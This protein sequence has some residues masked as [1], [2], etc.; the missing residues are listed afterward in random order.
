MFKHI[1]NYQFKTLVRSKEMWFWSL[2]F[3]LVLAT[4]FN[5]AFSNMSSG[6]SFSSVNIAVVNNE[7]F[8]QE[9]HFKEL[10]EQL[11]QDNDDKI[12][13]VK[14]IDEKEAQ[15]LLK[16]NEISGYIIVQDNINLVFKNVGFNQTIVKSVVDSYY[17]TMSVMKNV[18]KHNPEAIKDGVLELLGEKHNFLKDTSN[19]DVDVMVSYFYALIAMVC[20]YGAN[21]S[22]FM[23][24]QSEANL[25]K[26]GARTSVA[27]TH[28]FK[29]IAASLLIA[30]II[31][32]LEVLL[33]LAYLTFVLGI[34]FGNQIIPILILTFFGC[35]AGSTLGIIVSYTNRKKEEVKI[36]ITMSIIMFLSFLSG[37][38]IFNI[39]YLVAQHVPILGYINPATMISDALYS[40][41]YYETYE[42]FIFNVV[43]LII[44]SV[45]MIIIS[46]MFMRRKKYDSI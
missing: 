24:S 32:Y 29:V 8:Q 17:Q 34:N 6:T 5:L 38:M 15:D 44:F 1:F 7:E 23:V 46:Y 25:S 3:P 36:A 35:I 42:Q 19:N 10:I 11:S 31:H 4:F 14:Y 20:L 33:L 30:L 22:V 13:N 43:S 27:P 9:N 40:L 26:K 37:L 12:F 18:Y 45:I 2:I 16:N 39:K 28:K 21:F 41:Y